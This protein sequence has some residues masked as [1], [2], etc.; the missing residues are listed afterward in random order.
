VFVQEYVECTNSRDRWDE[1]VAIVT[2]DAPVD[3]AYPTLVVR[4]EKDLVSR[5]E[6]EEIVATLAAP[7]TT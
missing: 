5:A 1:P 4:G 2:V 3:A 6:V 7:A